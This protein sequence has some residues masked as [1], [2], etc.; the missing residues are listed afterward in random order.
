M[1]HY[2]LLMFTSKIFLYLQRSNSLPQL[3][4]GESLMEELGISPSVKKDIL[5][6]IELQML[7]RQA[8]KKVKVCIFKV[9]CSSITNI[10]FIC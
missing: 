7:K 8:L 1:L 9:K 4:V 3:K 6:D 5:S 10:I 2:R